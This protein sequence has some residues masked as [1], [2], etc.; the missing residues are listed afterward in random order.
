MVKVIE[1]ASDA[2]DRTISWRL[3]GSVFAAGAVLFVM[4]LAF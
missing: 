3:S 4:R 2:V 1:T